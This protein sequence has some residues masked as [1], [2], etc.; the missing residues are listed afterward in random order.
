MISE[1]AHSN[2]N[3]ASIQGTCK[4]KKH[5]HAA[6][7]KFF[8]EMHA[9]RFFRIRFKADSTI[10]ANLTAKRT[11]ILPS[12]LNPYDLLC[13][14]KSLVHRA[15]GNCLPGSGEPSYHLSSSLATTS[16]GIGRQPKRPRRRSC[17]SGTKRARE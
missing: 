14:Q 3:T 15:C 4:K 9:T 13:L 1:L 16:E 17:C 5:S 11:V 6:G 12:G 7:Y 2:G 8:Y 10:G